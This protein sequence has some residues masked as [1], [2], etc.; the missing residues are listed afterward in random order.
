MAC[1]ASPVRSANSARTSSTPQCC[2]APRPSPS[3][4]RA[5]P[6]TPAPARCPQGDVQSDQA[7]E[8][9]GLA[10]GGARCSGTPPKPASC[11]RSLAVAPL[12]GQHFADL[13]AV[14]PPS[15]SRCPFARDGSHICSRYRRAAATSSASR[16][17]T[18]SISRQFSSPRSVA[19]RRLTSRPSP[20]HCRASAASP[21][22]FASHAIHQKQLHS[23]WTSISLISP[24]SRAARAMRE[25]ALDQRLRSFHPAGQMGHRQH[26]RAVGFAL[27][28]ACLRANGHGLLRL[29]AGPA[30]WP[31]KMSA[32]AACA[33]SYRQRSAIDLILLC[34]PTIGWK[35]RA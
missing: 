35:L 32:A 9:R 12:P 27:R 16:S 34:R 31:W 2:T 19:S 29:G 6:D 30:Y 8:R 15:S 14:P 7:R 22:R 26:E 5:A 1:A 20:A 3:A 21:R 28:P 13:R 10:V 23:V 11:R 18:A 24:R 4:H 17:A 25:G 33:S